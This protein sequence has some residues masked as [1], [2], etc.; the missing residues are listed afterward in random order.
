R[1]KE[2][3]RFCC[4]NPECPHESLLV[5]AHHKKFRSEGGS[6]L[7]ENLDSLCRPDHKRNVHA[8]RIRLVD[9]DVDG[10]RATLWQYPR[11]R[12]VLRFLEEPPEVP[13]SFDRPSGYAPWR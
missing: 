5:E 7:D 2:R 12:Y 9:V 11:R 3:N 4:G 10:Y 8:G 6:D 13:R 1:V